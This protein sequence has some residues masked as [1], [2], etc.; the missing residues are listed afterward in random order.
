MRVEHQQK[1]EKGSRRPV[2]IYAES[3]P[4]WLAPASRVIRNLDLLVPVDAPGPHENFSD[5]A[6]E[7]LYRYAQTFRCN[8]VFSYSVSRIVPVRPTEKLAYRLR[9]NLV[10]VRIYDWDTV[11]PYSTE[12]REW[13]REYK[14]QQESPIK[15]PRMPQSSFPRRPR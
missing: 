9:A 12:L 5:N 1:S 6:R 4:D 14:R 2:P 15:G 8:A 11:D 7:A 3:V 13:E 10:R